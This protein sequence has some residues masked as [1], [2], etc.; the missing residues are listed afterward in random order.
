MSAPVTGKSVLLLAIGRSSFRGQQDAA[1]GS[2][3][4]TEWLLSGRC[5]IDKWLCAHSHEKHE[6][7]DPVIAGTVVARRTPLAWSAGSHRASSDHL[8]Q[9]RSGLDGRPPGS[10]VTGS[11]RRSRPVRRTHANHATPRAERRVGG[12][13]QHA[14]RHRQPHKCAS[15]LCRPGRSRHSTCECRD[16][17]PSEPSIDSFYAATTPECA[18]SHEIA[19]ERS[20]GRQPH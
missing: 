7:L 13:D 8:R 5:Q 17:R 20:E 6:A 16:R 19:G 18:K 1:M 11:A 12:C 2:L 9:S 10:G 14:H 4:D 3:R 15:A